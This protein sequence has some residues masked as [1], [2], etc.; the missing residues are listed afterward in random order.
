MSKQG[1][2]CV[3]VRKGL[4]FKDQRILMQNKVLPGKNTFIN[5]NMVVLEPFSFPFGN[6]TQRNFNL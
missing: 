6:T 3:Y 2:L 4:E 5:T 1:F